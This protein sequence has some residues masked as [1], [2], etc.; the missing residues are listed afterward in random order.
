M[1]SSCFSRG[2]EQ[3]LDSLERL[4]ARGIISGEID[5]C[6]SRCEG[7]CHTGP[8]VSIDDKVYCNVIP[9]ALPEIILHEF[10]VMIDNEGNSIK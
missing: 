7:K 8:V 6:G 5:L 3:N 1:G 2:N 10:G 4:I 9:D